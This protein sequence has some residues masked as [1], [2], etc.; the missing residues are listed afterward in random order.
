M[1]GLLKSDLILRSE[2]RKDAS[3]RD[4]TGDEICLDDHAKLRF[5]TGTLGDRVAASSPDSIFRYFDVDVARLTV[6]CNLSRLVEETDHDLLNAVSEY[7]L[8]KQSLGEAYG[9]EE[10]AISALLNVEKQAAHPSPPTRRRVP[11][12]DNSPE[13]AELGAAAVAALDGK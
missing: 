9:R 8:L 6:R 12:S 4:S 13:A 5:D 3:G 7:G 11:L 1:R 2:L 10:Y